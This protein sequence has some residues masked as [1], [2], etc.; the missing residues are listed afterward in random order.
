MA[1]R[2]PCDFRVVAFSSMIQF[3]VKAFS[4]LGAG[5]TDISNRTEDFV[6]CDCFVTPALARSRRVRWQ[7]FEHRSR[8]VQVNRLEALGN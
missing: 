3:R 6:D 2:A 7:R 1:S 8:G 4:G 5:A